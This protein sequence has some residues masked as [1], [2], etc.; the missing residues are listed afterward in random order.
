MTDEKKTKVKGSI[1]T[2]ES[3]TIDIWPSELV[4]A[5]IPH[6]KVQDV[7]TVMYN[8]LLQKFIE[9]DPTLAELDVDWHY[10]CWELEDGFDYHKGLPLTKTVR[11]FNQF[12][13]DSL[14][15]LEA[16]KGTLE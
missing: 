8:L 3:V 9:A 16:I 7:I 15:I 12:E 6:M 14:A 13:L 2:V 4:K 11:K 1:T 5:A 10:K